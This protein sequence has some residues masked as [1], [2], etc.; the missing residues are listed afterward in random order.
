MTVE[1]HLF[2]ICE[3]VVGFGCYAVFN[4][5]VVLGVLCDVGRG[6]SLEAFHWFFW[7]TRCEAWWQRPKGQA[8]RR[9]KSKAKEE[10]EKVRGTCALVDDYVSFTAMGRTTDDGLIAPI[11]GQ[12]NSAFTI[13]ST[14]TTAETFNTATTNG[15]SY[16]ITEESL[17]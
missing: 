15:R 6:P 12:T 10:K 9:S 13:S 17:E 11:V 4:S 8:K 14:M 7:Y 1:F 16:C 5:C 2:L 3:R